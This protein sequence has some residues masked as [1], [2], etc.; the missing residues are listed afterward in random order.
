MAFE[1]KTF[2]DLVEDGLNY[3]KANTNSI[4]SLYSGGRA[5]TL[6]EVNALLLSE[7]Y[8]YVNDRLKKAA[9]DGLYTALDFPPLPA[10][11]AKVQLVFTGTAGTVIPA[12]TIVQTSPG[13]YTQIIQFSTDTST[14]IPTGSTSVTVNATALINGSIGNVA[15]NTLT[16]LATPISG[17]TSVTNPSPAYGGVD[18]ETEQQRAYRFSQYIQSLTQGTVA[19][20][21]YAAQQISGVA[22][23]TVIEPPIITCHTL[24]GT[25]YTDQSAEANIPWGIPFAAFSSSPSVG[26]SLYI[27][28]N[29]LFNNV[30]INFATPGAGI[31]GS[32]QY[33]NGSNWVALSATDNTAS[34]SK[35]GSV[36]FTI[37]TDWQATTINGKT[38]FYIR[39]TLTS[40][41]ITTVPT[42]YHI[43]AL[44]PPP[45]WVNLV[46]YGVN[47][48]SNS[49]LLQ[50]VAQAIYNVKAAGIQVNVIPATVQTINISLTATV[51]QAY[52]NSTTQ[53]NIINAVTSY[54]NNL[55]IGQPLYLSQLTG[56]IMGVNGGSIVANVNYTSPTTDV[57]VPASTL[58]I[59][60]TIT[61]TLQSGS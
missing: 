12:G 16:N 44:N 30:Y 17:I 2:F 18:A 37:P 29:V 5:R 52:N 24:A 43:I 45:G 55:N 50:Q 35:S 56:A 8:L 27:G 33:W 38:A 34:L 61:V 7:L 51:P 11:P 14:Q 25:T 60:G 3:L 26:D 46:V 39:F 57:I 40:A 59:P 19:A 54:I 58:I 48:S 15:A 20:L 1:L 22:K 13:V 42:I 36:T 28:A 10:M 21:N 49:S 47:G 32:W 4:T 41:T 6:I 31:T 9:A 53:K 23:T